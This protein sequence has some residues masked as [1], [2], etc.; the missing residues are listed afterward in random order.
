MRQTRLVDLF[1][2][3]GI[4]KIV[5]LV[6]K[7]VV[8]MLEAAVQQELLTPPL[9][10]SIGRFGRTLNAIDFVNVAIRGN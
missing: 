8:Q 10:L 9:G 6:A 1:D 7:D 5:L 2:I 3:G 4:E